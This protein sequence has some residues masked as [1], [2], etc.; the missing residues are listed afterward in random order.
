M[1]DELTR[2]LTLRL[3]VYEK[4]MQLL[5]KDLHH[6]YHKQ[7]SLGIRT[8][9]LI[10]D[11]DEF[12]S[13]ETEGLKRKLNAAAAL[14]KERED[15]RVRLYDR[16]EFNVVPKLEQVP[17]HARECHEAIKA[18]A[19]VARKL[20]KKKQGL[21][22]ARAKP[23]TDRSRITALAREVH[24]LGV[25]IAESNT[26]VLRAVEKCESTKLQ[27]LRDMFVEY[28][29]AEMAYHARSLHCLTGFVDVINSIDNAAEIQ[30]VLEKVQ[31]SEHLGQNTDPLTG[32]DDTAPVSGAVAQAIQHGQQQKQAYVGSGGPNTDNFGNA[33]NANNAN[34]ANN[35]NYANN[36]GGNYG[37][38]NTGGG[39]YGGGTNTAGGG[40]NG[41]NTNYNSNNANN[42]ANY[43]NS[44]GN[45]GNSNG[46]YGNNGNNNNMQS[47]SPGQV[48]TG[49][50]DPSTPAGGYGGGGATAVQDFRGGDRS[51]TTPRGATAVEAFHQP[52]PRTTTRQAAW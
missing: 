30:A 7:D 2:F 35:A 25:T 29:H 28:A 40:T 21:A 14:L 39:N 32:T 11:L 17:S 4:S 13:N 41:A 50:R 22:K 45:Y 1:T 26:R 38:A 46:N 18:R 10:E 49:S 42:N 44:N 33:N 19:V 27:N 20:L 16:Y 6:V 12:A 36:T 3:D 47:A 23:G 9:K 43:G 34:I 5:G 37:G 48:P 52:D 51:P 24:D 15:A 8:D 31:L